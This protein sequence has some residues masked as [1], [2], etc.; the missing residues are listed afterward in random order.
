MKKL[1]LL[2]SIK[3]EIKQKIKYR[4]EYANKFGEVFTDFELVEEHVSNIDEELFKDPTSTFLDPCAGWGQ[5][6][7]VLIEKLMIGLEEWEP[8]EEKRW[9]WIL[10]N[11][12]FMVEIQKESCDIIGGFFNPSGELK[13]NLFNENFLEWEY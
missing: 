10:E 2:K 13:L 7:I 1:E 4:R 5:Y 8:N 11:Q 9:K 6:P 3:E 12:I